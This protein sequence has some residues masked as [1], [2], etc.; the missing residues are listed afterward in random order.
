[1]TTYFEAL[2]HN[3]N[4]IVTDVIP[5][6]KAGQDPM[7]IILDIERQITSHQQ[8]LAMRIPMI[9]AMLQQEASMPKGM[10]LTRKVAGGSPT[11]SVKREFGLKKGLSKQRTYE[12]FSLLT[13]FTA[14]IIDNIGYIYDIYEV[15]TLHTWDEEADDGSYIYTSPSGEVVA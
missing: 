13:E 12:V 6:M 5:H 15:S 11:A 9:V 2:E 3:W 4:V 7:D 1:M 14:W 10:S 8:G